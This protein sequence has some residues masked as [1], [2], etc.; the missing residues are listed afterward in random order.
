[1]NYF[2]IVQGEGL[3][4]TTQ[5]LALRTMLENKGH[6]VSA[7]FLGNS[8]FHKD[9]ELYRSVPHELF[10]SPVLLQRS[11][12]LG[13]TLFCTFLYNLL[14][15]PLYLFAIIR[16]A[17]R[18]RISDAQ[19]VIVFYD[20]VG[21]LGSFFSFS[22]KPV[23]SISHHFFFSHPSFKWPEKRKVERKMLIFH[24]WLASLGARKKLAL[25]FTPED[26]MPEKK[27]IIVPPLLRKEIL[28]AMPVA[29]NH[30][31]IY[32]LQSGFLNSIVNIAKQMHQREFRV[33]LHEVTNE[34][35]LPANIQVSIISGD[36]FRESIISSNIV[37]STAGFET[38]AEAIYLNKPLVVIPS[39]GHFEQYC[40]AVDVSRAGAG[41]VSTDFDIH[42]S[43]F[44]SE[45]PAHFQFIKWISKTEEIFLQ[46][47]TE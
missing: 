34:I 47:L 5:S 13:I 27:L 20:M 37:V 40:N 26:N 22:G 33:F 6:T 31:H 42:E 25:S 1:M 45:N 10:Y 19:A 14:L 30:I 17:Y 35:D 44:Y 43:N 39:K 11:D 46:N 2:F 12:K 4:H 24:S 38:L 29:G 23:F 21:Q 41:T 9:N 3:G 28:N 18:I 15:S 8:L 32:C 36:K 16:I 7:T